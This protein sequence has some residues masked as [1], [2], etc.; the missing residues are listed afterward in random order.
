MRYLVATIA[1]LILAPPAGA[2][3]SIT[4]LEREPGI[5]VPEWL[6]ESVRLNKWLNTNWDSLPTE[7]VP[8]VREHVYFLIGAA[9]QQWYQEHGSVFY[10]GDNPIVP[11]LF[12]W[13][14]RL[15]VYG[16]D[17]IVPD[18]IGELDAVRGSPLSGR[19]HLEWESPLLRVHTADSSW[20]ARMPYYFMLWQVE[21]I[22]IRGVLTDAL[23]VSPL[24]APHEEIEGS[25]QAT[26]M[27]LSAVQPLE[28]FAAG[29][30]VQFGLQDAPSGGSD[31]LS[32]ATVVRGV[33][34]TA[35]LHKEALFWMAGERSFVALFTGLSGTFQANHVHFVNFVQSLEF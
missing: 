34:A 20:S 30:K 12:N 21:Q 7:D 8:A 13:G 6:V 25:S 32:S 5:G 15:G 23:V 3:Y 26:I 29:W 1:L 9:V 14:S 33:D 11:L 28:D 31:I 4:P 27:L 18:L 10:G 35:P 2:Q 17:L 22:D 16:A 24:F 19:F